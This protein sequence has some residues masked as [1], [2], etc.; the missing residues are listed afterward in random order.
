MRCIPR[1]MAMRFWTIKEEE[2]VIQLLKDHSIEE[3]AAKIGRSTT[4][5]TIKAV[6]SGW[7]KTYP[8]LDFYVRKHFDPEMHFRDQAYGKVRWRQHPIFKNYYGSDTGLVWSANR[9][10]LLS[11]Y[12]LAHKNSS[13]KGYWISLT[14]EPGKWGRQYK[15]SRFIAECWF[16]ITPDQ[17]VAHKDRNKFNNDINNLVIATKS[18]LGKA[19]GHMAKGRRVARLNDQ[20]QVIK[21]W[22]S[23]RACAL[24][25]G[26]S[27][28]T[29][30]DYV[31]G[32]LVRKPN[33]HNYKLA[34]Y[35]PKSKP[36]DTERR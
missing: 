5:I 33:S 11:P 14:K 26:V 17:M 29:V 23:A 22:R 31:N 10:R 1:T 3:V 21:V 15:L 4:A 12:K 8:E 25:L 28:Q 24:D 34:W 27:Y 20:G 6:R 35:L 36:R 30:L 13:K 16:N 18:Q 19:T 9:K 32:K 7:H 2:L